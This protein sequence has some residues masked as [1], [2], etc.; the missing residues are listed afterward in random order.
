[1]ALGAIITAAKSASGTMTDVTGLRGCM[2]RFLDFIKYPSPYG[3][4][5]VWSTSCLQR[6]HHVWS[7]N[8]M[9]GAQAETEECFK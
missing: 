5:Y 3:Y 2:P 8:I 1:M 9:F 6:K 7:T 4:G